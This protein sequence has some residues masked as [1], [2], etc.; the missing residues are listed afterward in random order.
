MIHKNYNERR[1]FTSL[2][3]TQVSFFVLVP[4][5]SGVPFYHEF[6]VLGI[7]SILLS[8]LYAAASHRVFL[9]I[10]S[11]LLVLASY[12]WVGPDLLP[13]SADEVLRLLTVA[14]SFFFTSVVVVV[15]VSRHA[16]VTRE[17]ILGGINAY[18]LIGLAFMLLHSATLLADPKAYLFLGSSVELE[19][20]YWSAKA[21]SS[22]LYF[23]FTTLT[24]LGYGDIIPFSSVARLLTSAE[25]IVG[26]LYFAIVLAR[27][28]GLEIG[29]REMRRRSEES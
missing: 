25:A 21:F 5:L 28:V 29:Q 1:P 18:F 13:G 9:V 22:M 12:A 7:F 10:S 14:A 2:L 16:Q 4:L 24:T 19:N 23:S 6:M 17:T 27:L 26:Q 20:S 3:I 8:G 11:G 15:A